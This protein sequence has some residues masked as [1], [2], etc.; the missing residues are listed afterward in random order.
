M[1]AVAAG[2]VVGQ[3]R[4]RVV[5]PEITRTQIVQ[6]AGASGDFSPLHTDE[7]AAIRAGYRG[8]MAH[9]MLVMA[10]SSAALADWIGRERLTRYGVRFLAPVWPGDTLTTAVTVEAVLREADGEHVDFRISTTNQ[11]GALVLTGHASART[12]AE[13]DLGGTGAPDPDD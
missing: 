12:S 7:A 11:D 5:C 6:Y 8:V 3:R 9:G 10:A 4:E 13:P 1:S 2:F